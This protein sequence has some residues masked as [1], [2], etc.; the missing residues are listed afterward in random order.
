MNGAAPVIVNDAGVHAANPNYNS[1]PMTNSTQS[2]GMLNGQVLQIVSENQKARGNLAVVSSSCACCPVGC[3][4]HF[5]RVVVMRWHWRIPSNVR[6]LP[7]PF[8]PQVKGSSPL[9]KR[10]FTLVGLVGFVAAAVTVAVV[11]TAQGN[12]SQVFADFSVSERLP[13][14]L[15]A[16][17][18][19]RATAA[20]AAAV[21]VVAAL[22]PAVS[23]HEAFH[24]V[25]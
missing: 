14:Q 10:V 15:R 18:W 7:T 12:E 6:P 25:V 5:L 8:L 21:A 13:L 2:V 3:E 16:L 9:A 11:L 22:L 1:K 24:L 17:S 20:V 4:Q 23:M 19:G